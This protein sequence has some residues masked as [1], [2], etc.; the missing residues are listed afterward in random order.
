MVFNFVVIGTVYVIEDLRKM[1]FAEGRFEYGYHSRDVNV[2]LGRMSTEC[3]M[4]FCEH[5]MC[6]IETL[7]H[8]K[9]K[10]NRE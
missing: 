4:H 9:I 2:H 10:R 6:S 7:C 8:G 1:A 3:I 5:D